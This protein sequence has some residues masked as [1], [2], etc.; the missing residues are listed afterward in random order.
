MESLFRQ[1]ILPI[2]YC[3][4]IY[5]Y[6]NIYTFG[7]LSCCQIS[8][9]HLRIEHGAVLR[10]S[11]TWIS[12]EIFM[13]AR[14]KIKIASYQYRNSRWGS[15]TLHRYPLQWRHNEH[16][17]VSNHH[18]HD[19]LLNRL[20]MRRSKKTPK[21]RVTGICEGIHRWPVNSPH[22]GPVTRKIFPFG[23]VSM[24]SVLPPRLNQSIHGGPVTHICVNILHWFRER[25]V[26]C[27]APSVYLNRDGLFSISTPVL[28][29]S[30]VGLGTY[31]KII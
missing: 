31:Q 14:Y 21:L 18:H 6:T 20:F 12:I 11:D 26:T 19:C 27:S 7:T 16:G 13:Y 2:R 30:S 28:G 29:I 10:I 8:A 15:K 4:Y 22:K 5:I 23:D 25:L 1:I 3:I 17:G 24:T 9:T